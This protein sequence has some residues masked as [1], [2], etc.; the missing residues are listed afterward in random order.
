[1]F[2]RLFGTYGL[3]LL[4]AI[5]VLGAV[6]VQRVERYYAQQLAER[7][8]TKTFLIREIVQGRDNQSLAELDAALKQLRQ[9]Q[10][11]RVTLI[12]E[13]GKVLVDTDRDPAG[14][15]NHDGRPEI[16]TA[17]ANGFGSATRLSDTVHESFGY[18]AVHVPATRQG[19]AFVRIAVPLDSIEDE[20][21]S[22][23]R[24]VW[25][26]AAV[27]GVLAMA[28]AFWLARRIALPIQE[29]TEGA[30]SIAA[31]DYGHK[32]YASGADEVRTLAGSFNHMS[33]RLATQFAQLD[34]ERQQLRA[35]LSGMIEGVVALD[36]RQRILFAN[37][38]ALTLLDLSGQTVV[39]RK[40]WE[41]IRQRGLTELVR[42]ALAEQE[43]L[44]E[45]LTWNG[46]AFRNLTAHAARLQGNVARGAVLVL[47]DTTELRRLERVR[48]EFVANVS[49]ELKTPLAVI[50]ACV[51]TLLDGAIDDP[52]HRGPFLERIADQT[53]R[54]HNLILD[55]ISLARIES[56]VEVFAFQPIPVAEAVLACLERHSARAESN[57]QHLE[58]ERGGAVEPFHAMDNGN[59]AQAPPAVAWAD[60]EAVGQILDNLVDNALKYTPEGGRIRVGWHTEDGQVCLQV[61]DTGIGIPERD[62]PRIFERFYRVDK[63]RSRELGGTGLGLSIVKHL[64]QAM[65]GTVRASSVFGQG[66]TFQVRLPRA[67]ET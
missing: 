57:G 37:E 12:D 17:R 39:G 63:A 32:V 65:H 7:L 9:E 64:V 27:T 11:P 59:A 62:L 10:L 43:P 51:E 13:Q 23:R 5:G 38:R 41:V 53:Q 30:R 61:L 18:A 6:V 29:L 55:L 48:Q 36:A 50:Q 49:H 19:V 14:M 21:A 35:I 54:L 16:V 28:L 42:R 60:E 47:H 2:W 22:L 26:T 31:G 34:E 20:L 4:A 15:D 58:V 8:R 67:P 45:E 52:H 25:T 24:L 44:R 33:E 3:L 46:P 66:S 40:L 1:M 56:G